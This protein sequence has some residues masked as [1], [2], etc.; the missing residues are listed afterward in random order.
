MFF[1]CNLCLFEQ[2]ISRAIFISIRYTT[3]GP[4]GFPLLSSN[5]GLSPFYGLIVASLRTNQFYM[6]VDKVNSKT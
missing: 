1:N 6:K 2:D 3:A 5:V 4:Q